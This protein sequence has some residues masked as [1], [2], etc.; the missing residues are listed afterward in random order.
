MTNSSLR[1]GKNISPQRETC[2][3][4]MGKASLRGGT[5]RQLYPILRAAPPDRENRHT[6]KPQS[7]HCKNPVSS[8]AAPAKTVKSKNLTYFNYGGGV[9]WSI[10]S[11]FVACYTHQTHHNICI[12][13]KGILCPLLI[14]TA[15]DR[16]R[17]I[18]HNL[19]TKTK[20]L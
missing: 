9:F 14:L 12:I 19:K 2:P 1:G 4:A 6:D 8:S 20:T 15:I 16:K 7:L 17:I 13:G 5:N 18:N 10:R 11:T 3:S